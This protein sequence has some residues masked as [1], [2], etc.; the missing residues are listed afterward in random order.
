MGVGQKLN[1]TTARK[2]S[3]LVYKSFNTLQVTGLN[4]GLVPFRRLTATRINVELL[5]DNANP[6]I[7]FT[8]FI[9]NTKNYKSFIVYKLE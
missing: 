7:E 6:V 2:P 5:C 9:K 1:H 3:T 4:L 8:L